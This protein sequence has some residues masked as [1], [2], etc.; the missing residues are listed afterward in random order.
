LRA[1]RFARGRLVRLVEKPE[2]KP[3]MN[4]ESWLLDR[5]LQ[6]FNVQISEAVGVPSKLQALF[7]VSLLQMRTP[8]GTYNIK[9]Q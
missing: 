8:I 7:A 4:K 9:V 5:N 2:Q 3:L 1:S 6:D